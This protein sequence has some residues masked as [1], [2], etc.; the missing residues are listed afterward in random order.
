MTQDEITQK[1]KEIEQSLSPEDR[2]K[3]L[4]LLNEHVKVLNADIEGVLTELHKES[5]KTE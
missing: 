2:L 1:M 5:E 3:L 4:N